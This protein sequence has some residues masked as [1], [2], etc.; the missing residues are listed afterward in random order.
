MHLSLLLSLFFVPLSLESPSDDLYIK[1]L[2]ADE[3]QTLDAQNFPKLADFFIKNAT[4]NAGI[5]PT[6]Y[7]IDSIKAVLATHLPPEVITQNNISTESITL[8][9][10]FDE[11][12]AASTAIGVVYT[13][14]AYIGQG[15][16]TG[17]ALIFFA[18]Y[19]D[20]YVKTGDFAH[21]GGWKISE[22]FFVPFG[23]PVGNPE[24][25]PPQLRA[26]LS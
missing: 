21:H 22:R 16:L 26:M 15:N 13:T 14:A 2:T 5:G 3:A 9:P 8:L 20:K 7:G 1:K 17:Q 4:Y 18:K 12:G 10:P 23:N 11:Q 24:V 25:L 6:V 19:E